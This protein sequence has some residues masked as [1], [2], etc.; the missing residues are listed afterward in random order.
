MIRVDYGVNIKKWTSQRAILKARAS[1]SREEEGF[2]KLA[3]LLY[4]LRETN[5]NTTT[6]IVT[7]DGKFFRA[8]FCPGACADAFGE[9]LRVAGIDACH[10]KTK[11]GGVLLV[12]T[13][14][15]GNLNIFPS[16]LALPRASASTRGRGF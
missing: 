14:L 16:V 5:R 3:S 8:F 7:K 2:G 9:S 11:H 1:L 12:L 10:L 6:D 13:V 4:T 15:D